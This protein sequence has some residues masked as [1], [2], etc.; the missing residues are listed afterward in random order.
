VGLILIVPRNH[1]Q[2]K[3]QAKK[4]QTH[5]EEDATEEGRKAVKLRAGRKSS[6]K[7]TEF[8]TGGFNPL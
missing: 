5:P 8:Q 2:A 1:H 4:N 7:K 6:R 3:R